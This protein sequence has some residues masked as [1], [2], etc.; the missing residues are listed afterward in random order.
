SKSFLLKLFESFYMQRWNDRMRPF[1]L[2]EADKQ[3]HKMIAAWMITRLHDKPV[4]EIALIEAH[5]FE[6]L[7]RIEITDLKPQV[8]Y[9]I[10]E[11]K[12]EYRRLNE[13]IIKRIEPLLKPVGHGLFERFSD[14]FLNETPSLEKE[15]IGAAHIFASRWE[16][17]LVKQLNGYNTDTKKISDHLDSEWEKQHYLKG[18]SRFI[19]EG[20]YV[21]FMNLCGQLRFQYRWS[22]RHRSPR[23]SVLGHMLMVAQFGYLFSLDADGCEK[24]KVNNYFTGLFH[25]LPEVLTRDIISPVKRSVEGMEELI[26][27]YEAEQM[28]IEVF[29]LLPDSWREEIALYT[30][31]EFSDSVMKGGS[32]VVVKPNEISQKYNQDVFSPRDGRLVRAADHLSAYIEAH[33]AVRN[34]SGSPDIKEALIHLSE[35]Y[36]G[37][38][39]CGVSIGQVFEDFRS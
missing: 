35:E 16:F 33:E 11:N 38:A 12:D 20:K 21:E 19:S 22:N 14:Y 23:T 31:N 2:V 24:R 27:Q 32:R 13:W 5:L 7:Q 26:A 37:K 29:S 36:R 10:K 1:E 17:G 9:R 15:I 4:S 25:D 6:M 3:A 18:V 30:N 28:E 39:M 8:Y 34:G